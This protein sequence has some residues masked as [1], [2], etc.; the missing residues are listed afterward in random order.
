[1]RAKGRVA[2]CHRPRHR[3]REVDMNWL[4]LERRADIERTIAGALRNAIHSHGPIMLENHALAAK[5]VYGALK[6]LAKSWRRDQGNDSKKSGEHPID[7]SA[8]MEYNGGR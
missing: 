8:G 2:M 3:G 6:S 1:M 4:N 7:K 5:R